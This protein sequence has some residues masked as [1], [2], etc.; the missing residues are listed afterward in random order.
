MNQ[1]GAMT[2]RTSET[3]STY[4]E[5]LVGS[6]LLLFSLLTVSGMF[7]TGYRNV[8]TAGNTTMGMAGTRQLLEDMRRL[9]YANLVNL[10]GF[11]TDDP[12]TQPADDPEREVARRWR[13]AMAGEGVGWSFTAEEKTRWTDLDV[14]GDELDGVGRLAVTQQTATMTEVDVTVSVPGA[15]RDIR[16]TTLMADL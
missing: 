8:D 10:D 11:D 14:Q 1:R 3:G 4:L 6:L 7:I 5:V 15:W 2:A 9:P 12:N 16:V 13:F